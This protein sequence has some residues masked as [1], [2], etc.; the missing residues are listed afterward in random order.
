MIVVDTNIIGYLYLTSEFSELA[1]AARRQ[2]E[3]WAAPPLWRS[4]LCNVLVRYLRNKRLSLKDAKEMMDAAIELLD[5]NEHDVD[6]DDVLTLAERSGCSGYD[7]EFV[8]LAEKL[9]VPLVTVDKKILTQFPERAISLA[10]FCESSIVR[11]T[12]H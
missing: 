3:C 9:N 6:Y 8:A 1:V 5:G 10:T 12:T 4:E 7:C 2:D 11:S